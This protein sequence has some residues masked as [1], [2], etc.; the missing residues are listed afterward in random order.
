MAPTPRG[1]FLR[2]KGAPNPLN[3]YTVLLSVGES[4]SFNQ[5]EQAMELHHELL[6]GT[7]KILCDE[8][9]KMI[10]NYISLEPLLEA[11]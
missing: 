3:S 7:S 11:V 10:I 1:Q 5:L 6:K 4:G 8:N 9:H 2:G